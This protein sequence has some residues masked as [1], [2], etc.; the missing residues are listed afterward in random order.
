MK[1]WLMPVQEEPRKLHEPGTENSVLTVGRGDGELLRDDEVGEE[2]EEEAGGEAGVE[3]PL[4]PAPEPPPGLRLASHRIIPLMKPLIVDAVRSSLQ[5]SVKNST[6]FSFPPRFVAY[7]GGE[8]ASE[9]DEEGGK[10]R[11]VVVCW[12]ASSSKP[13]AF[14]AFVAS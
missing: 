1:Q 12:L 14:V 8:R 6:S 13:L 10:A 11:R 2:D 4:R 9:R 7:M 5:S 3:V